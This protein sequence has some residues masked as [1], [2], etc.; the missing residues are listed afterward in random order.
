MVEHSAARTLWLRLAPA[1]LAALPGCGGGGAAGGFSTFQ[2]ALACEGPLEGTRD[3][4]GSILE[5]DGGLE[6]GDREGSAAAPG[7]VRAFLSFDISAIPGNATIQSAVLRVDLVSV[8]GA[9]FGTPPGGL[10][11]L[12]VE[13]L[14][15][16][17]TFPSAVAYDALSPSG[18][19]EVVAADPTLG[20]RSANVTF[21]VLM[22]H[23]LGVPR[24]QYRLRFTDRDKNLDGQDTGVRLV[25]SE[26]LAGQGTPPV[27]EVTYTV[28]H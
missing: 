26:D 28:P 5:A 19:Q 4:S 27:L 18:I 3:A 16:G 17:T 1:V 23:A 22:S 10:G 11:T 9:P 21:G 6:V 24:S 15:Y 13:I 20:V 25:D 14:A 2:V 7:P 12:V 8:R